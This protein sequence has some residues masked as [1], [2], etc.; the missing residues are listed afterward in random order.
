MTVYFLKMTE[1][2]NASPDY[3]DTL[4]RYYEEE[5]SGEAYFF[6]LADHFEE[7]D[8][9]ILLGKVERRAAEAVVPLLQKYGLEPRDESIIH[10]EGNSHLWGHEKFTWPE[11]LTHIINR[12]PAYLDDF[13]GLESMAPDEDLYALKTLTEHEVAA[14]DFAKKELAGDPDSLSPLLQ[15]LD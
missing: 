15:Y 4:L 6:A 10:A 14:I 9:I 12:Y 11:F 1:T 2:S 13:N 7:R 3:L 5:I 8:K